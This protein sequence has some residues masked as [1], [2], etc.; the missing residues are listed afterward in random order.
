VCQL[1]LK[2][3]VFLGTVGKALFSVIEFESLAGKCV[4]P[5]SVLRVAR[6][7]TNADICCLCQGL[8]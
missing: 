7:K 5:N 2:L 8:A 3:Y 4:L 1:R 6:G